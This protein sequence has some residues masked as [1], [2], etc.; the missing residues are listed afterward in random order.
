MYYTY[1]YDE[2]MTENLK[3]FP[4]LSEKMQGITQ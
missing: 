4:L 3:L 1:L 2:K